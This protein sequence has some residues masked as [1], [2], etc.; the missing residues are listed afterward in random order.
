[1]R[2]PYCGGLNPE[3][4]NFCVRCG[5]GLVNSTPPASGRAAVTPRPPVT[6][7]APSSYPTHTPR[8]AQPIP[9]VPASP[10][11]GNQPV[12]QPPSKTEF[13]TTDNGNRSDVPATVATA[14]AGIARQRTRKAGKL[15]QAQPEIVAQPVYPEAPVP[16]PPKTMEQLRGLHSGAQAYTEQSDVP[17]Y[18][19]KRIVRIIYPRCAHW[20]QVATL[21]AAL[22]QYEHPQFDTIIIQGL[23]DEHESLYAFS[24]GQLVFDRKVRLGGD[25]IRRYQIETS[26]GYASDSVR[27]V[28]SEPAR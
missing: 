27:V 22:Q 18:G 11:Q 25:W 20:Q 6:R 12:F 23:H 17:T 8:P 26:N 1:M 10:T 5:R 15:Y 19:K 24:N 3:K 14:Q 21:M 9:S 4:T 2:C 7:P 28:Q 16:F 13:I